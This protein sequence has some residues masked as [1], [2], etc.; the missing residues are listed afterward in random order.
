MRVE[1]RAQ[2]TSFLLRALADRAADIDA[3]ATRRGRSGHDLF[4]ANLIDVLVAVLTTPPSS[5]TRRRAGHRSLVADSTRV[6]DG[7]S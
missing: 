7:A 6:S 2:T 5:A 3:D 1:R 4:V